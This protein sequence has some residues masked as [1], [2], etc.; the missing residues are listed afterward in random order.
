MALNGIFTKKIANGYTLRVYWSAVQSIANNTTTPSLDIYLDQASGYGLYVSARSDNTL[1]VAGKTYTWSALAISNSGGKST[2]LASLTL[3]PIAHN[4]DGT[5]SVTMSAK[6]NIRATI[7]GTW[8]ESMTATGDITFDQ[9]MRATQPT[10]STTAADMGTSITIGTPREAASF[11][12]DLA[13]TFAGRYAVFATGVGTSYT[14]TIP[15]LAAHVPDS[16]SGVLT[17]SCITKSGG[18]VIGTKTVNLT[19]KV[20]ASVVPTISAVSVAE[21]VSGLAAQFGAFIRNKSAIKCTITAAGAKGSTI[22]TYNS[23]FQGAAYS[24]NTWTSKTL[25]T[26]GALTIATTV[27]DSRGRTANKNTTVN[28]LD[29]SPP[30]V[31]AFR[32]Y[33]CTSSGTPTDDGTAFAAVYAYSVP[34]LNGGNTAK[35]V[36]SYKRTSATSYTQAY[37]ATAL[38]QDRTQVVSSATFSTDYE[39]DIQLAVTDWFGT[40]TTYRATLPSAEVILDI[41]ADGKSLAIFKTAETAGALEVAGDTRITGTQERLGN[42]YTL[43]TPGV[44]GTA[45]YILMARIEITAANADT[46]ITFVFSQRQAEAPMTVHVSLRNSTATESS[47]SS[48]RYEG[49]NYGAFLVQ[50]NDL[51]WDL[52]VQK[53]STYDTITLQDWWTSHTMES[54]IRVT[55]PATL[56][57]ALP[58]TY[59]RA[60]PAKLDSL[61]DHIFPVG[62]VVIMYNHTNPGDYYGGTWTRISNAF[63]WGTTSGGTIGQTGGSSTHTLTVE[64]MPNHNHPAK[65]Y[66]YV[67]GDVNTSVARL[68]Y[69]QNTGT[70]YEAQSQ[71]W[72]DG[73]G[74]GKAHNNMPP[75]V[76]VSIWRRTA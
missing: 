61:L 66:S 37:T 6:Y 44:S 73:A 15:D 26:A 72:M 8:Y 38:S 55:F 36:L 45:G 52:Y 76:Q 46:P 69:K 1:T 21:T 67:A 42:K 2:K 63:L 71:N 20:P 75:Y 41:G 16:T 24:G 68:T 43:S 39:Y 11:T 70:N 28:V 33:R 4:A 62:F 5:K 60:T 74:G 17:I 47:L 49:S 65:A 3:D 9:I 40:T 27:T 53:G 23:T 50:L 31:S 35:A 29:Y 19:A 18:T 30:N 10:V 48:I 14:W 56:A 32:V 7:S 58:D 51:T 25:N 64:E 13:Y 54:R 12:H 22:K 59:Y 57:A 34:S